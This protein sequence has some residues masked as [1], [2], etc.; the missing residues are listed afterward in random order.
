MNPSNPEALSGVPTVPVAFECGAGA[1]EMQAL[2][3]KSP[4]LSFSVLLELFPV[5][6]V[7]ES[8]PVSWSSHR[9]SIGG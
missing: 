3:K 6:A 4:R 9:F 1:S 7:C 2:E 8:D 5:P